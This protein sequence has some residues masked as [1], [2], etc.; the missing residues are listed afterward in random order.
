VEAGTTFA[1]SFNTNTEI[2]IA[3]FSLA[4]GYAGGS[5][6]MTAVWP[7]VR[8]FPTH[9]G[10][11]TGLIMLGYGFGNLLDG[12]LFTFLAN[13]YNATPTLEVHHNGMTDRLFTA[14]VS[15]RVPFALRWLAVALLLFTLL[16]AAL[17]SEPTESEMLLTPTKE[18]E[19]ISKK[20]AFVS[21]EFWDM[22]LIVFFGCAYGLYI[23]NQ[24]KNYGMTEIHNDHLLSYIGTIAALCNAIARFFMSFIMDYISFKLLYCLNS[25]LQT[26]LSATI[27]FV[28]SSPELFGLWV[29]LSFVCHAANLSPFAV[30]SST[31]YGPQ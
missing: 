8:Y 28:V 30:A 25:L 13:P 23:T 3:G 19:E 21:W 18:V 14:E 1:L 17:V 9:K 20:Q 10:L 31:I 15:L 22:C 29:S 11:V 2:F 27:E 12:L 16:G 5:M 24:Y 7:S 6:V 4:V 26:F